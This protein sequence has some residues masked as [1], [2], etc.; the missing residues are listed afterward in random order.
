MVAN[1]RDAKARLVFMM[2]L[3][4]PLGTLRV[5]SWFRRGRPCG[6]KKASPCCP[7][8]ALQR[9]RNKAVTSRLSP[10]YVVVKTM[11]LG[12]VG[13]CYATSAHARAWWQ[14]SRSRRILR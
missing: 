11:V 3:L 2:L 13:A 7:K 9:R 1:V 6:Y 4:V 10:T 8:K 12:E 5:D 14:G